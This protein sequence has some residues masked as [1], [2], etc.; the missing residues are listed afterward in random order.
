MVPGSER[1]LARACALG[2]PR[3]MRTFEEAYF[4]E[5]E[6]V[7]ARFARSGL[8]ADDLK[9]ALR[10]KLFLPK[11]G[12]LPDVSRYRGRGA[13]RHWVRVVA[14]RM[15]I[16]LTRARPRDASAD[17]DLLLDQAAPGDD[18]ELAYLKRVCRAEF[19]V[20]FAQAVESLSF[21]QR[22]IVRLAFARGL[23][24][25]AVGVV[26]GVHAATARRW[27]AAARAA[28]LDAVRTD[29][30]SRLRVTPS[31]LQSI[32]RLIESRLEVAGLEDA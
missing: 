4:G 19:K 28:L 14:V 5:V 26:Y 9:Q 27:I 21:R 1:D 30:M 17:E 22:N 20:A 2:D 25:E 12:A 13:L 11:A 3:A 7:A 8:C 10:E 18:P 29:L 32:L 23:S 16:D 6:S 15:A 31:D 24:A